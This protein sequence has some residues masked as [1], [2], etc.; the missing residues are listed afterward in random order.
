MF[1]IVGDLLGDD[2]RG[3]CVYIFDNNLKVLCTPNTFAALCILFTH[4]QIYLKSRMVWHI[5]STTNTQSWER[6]R[7]RI[8]WTMFWRKSN[9]IYLYHMLFFTTFIFF[10]QVANYA[11]FQ[12]WTINKI[13]SLPFP[14][15]P[16]T[17]EQLPPNIDLHVPN[18]KLSVT[19][20]GSPFTLLFFMKEIYCGNNYGELDEIIQFPYK[21]SLFYHLKLQGETCIHSFIEYSLNI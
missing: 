1:F 6:L 21:I 13:V 17:R 18:S 15:S 16:Y 19:N 4:V 11:S 12:I 2:S 14:W 3:L 8:A 9:P 10:S 7:G 5:H 20:W